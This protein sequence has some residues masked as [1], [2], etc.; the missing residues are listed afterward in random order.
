M[1]S[2]KIRG[3]LLLS[4]H[5]I[6]LFLSGQKN[7]INQLYVQNENKVQEFINRHNAD[8]AFFYLHKNELLLENN[9]DT[10]LI[11]CLSLNRAQ[12]Y[13]LVDELAKSFEACSKALPYF[14]KSGDTFRES[15]CGYLICDYYYQK[16]IYDSVII[17]A[18]RYIPLALKINNYK[19]SSVLMLLK[20]RSIANKGDIERASRIFRKL[21]DFAEKN[22]DSL[23]TYQ[24]FLA[25]A[26]VY[27][28]INY[29]FA[30]EYLHKAEL[31]SKSFND[32]TKAG[33]YTVF[34]NTYRNS[35]LPD[36]ALF[37]YNKNL[38]CLDKKTDIIQ[39][40]ATIGNIGN[41]YNDLGR[42][43]EALTKQFE[44]LTYFKLAEDSMD[45]EIA[46]GT[47]ADIY[48]KKENYQEALKYYLQAI[49]IS[50][51]LGFAEELMYNYEGLY[52]CYEKTSRF[53]EAHEAYK[54]FNLFKDSI[55]SNEITKKLTEQELNFKYETKRK[56]DALVQKNK[57]LETASKFRTQKII[58]YS[59]VLVGFILLV[60]L[61]IT[62][63]NSAIRKKINQQLELS[64]SEIKTQKNIIETKNREITDSIMYASRIQQGILPDAEEIKDILPNCFVF[65]RPRDIVSGD[66]YWIKKLKGNSII[67]K[68]QLAGIVIADC[69]GHGVPGAF[70]SFIG[71]TIFNQTIGNNNI[72]TPADALNYLNQQLPL[73]LKSKSNTGQIN[74]GMEA[75]I[76]VYNKENRRVFYA[77]ANIHL[78]HIRNGIANEIKGDKHSIGLNAEQQK[79]FTNKELLLETGDCIYLF[80]DG[81]ADQFG[82]EK[83]K[84]FKYK[85][86][87]KLLEQISHLPINEQYQQIEENF[88]RWKG[89]LEQLDD[90]LVFGLRA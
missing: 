76:C 1:F 83:G 71:N 49:A 84:K 25:L 58:I 47:I 15:E 5:L 18:D 78:I 37:Y 81:Y 46:Y 57:D 48:L 26:G 21:V 22:K 7:D 16:S 82:G 6:V 88:D 87:I 53:K 41:L 89:N 77:G 72:E 63:R 50:E 17:N 28:E 30:L 61:F 52:K 70:M 43:D 67:G 36:S 39:Y 60:F 3:V 86:L 23:T 56:E 20:G 69:T 32:R 44:S 31:F 38:Q 24:T 27:Q 90:V 54:K 11:N 62:L 51:R 33:M 74:D 34:G 10:R 40:G 8:S 29:K 19:T 66:F 2:L 14:K 13:K 64:H 73:T 68:D 75:G 65:F 9:Q 80:S 55:R 59:A 79:T 35:N 42:T 4:F 45:I 85:N 12:Y